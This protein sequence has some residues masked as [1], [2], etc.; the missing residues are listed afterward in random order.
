M[1]KERNTEFILFLVGV[2]ILVV[3]LALVLFRGQRIKE[4]D[5]IART[6]AY[7]TSEAYYGR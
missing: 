6:D 1:S 5:I 4:Q 3:F 2:V 7:F